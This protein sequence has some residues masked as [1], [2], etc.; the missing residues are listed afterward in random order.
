MSP[1]VSQPVSNKDTKTTY[2]TSREAARPFQITEHRPVIASDE[3]WKIV[4][5]C[6]QIQREPLGAKDMEH[7][8][9]RS[10]SA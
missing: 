5:A 9:I 7:P 6:A 1:A 4:E 10:I 3:D 2:A 8:K